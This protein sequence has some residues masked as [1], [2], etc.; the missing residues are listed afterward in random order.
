[1]S[2]ITDLEV[3]FGAALGSKDFHR[4]VDKKTGQ[5]W[6]VNLGESATLYAIIVLCSPCSV[7]RTCV[8]VC[9]VLTRCIQT[10]CIS[11]LVSEFFFASSLVISISSTI[12]R[13]ECEC[14]RVCARVCVCVH[15]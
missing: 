1:M 3:T 4:I 5:G 10:M 13:G 11:L 12:R 6:D 8:T 9:A 15:V 14:V 2:A 7:E